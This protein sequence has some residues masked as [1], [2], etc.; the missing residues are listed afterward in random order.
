MRFLLAIAR[1]F[2]GKKESA[3]NQPRRAMIE[4]LE[5]REFLSAAPAPCTMIGACWAEV[6]APAINYQDVIHKYKG[7][8][9]TDLR[10]RPFKGTINIQSINPDTGRV[11]GRVSIPFL[12]EDYKFALRGVIRP[13]GTFTIT[14][15]QPGVS[16]RLDGSYTA[17]QHLVGNVSA[18]GA[19]GS[20]T[21]NID[22]HKI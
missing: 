3:K 19:P 7:T 4:P 8:I 6:S 16:A 18:K 21:G 13:D 12:V 15:K 1:L 10:P 17:K 14:F 5:G 22:F 11:T 20:V 2:F 9:Q